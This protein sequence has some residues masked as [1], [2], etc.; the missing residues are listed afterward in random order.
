MAF[1]VA[2]IYKPRSVKTLVVLRLFEDTFVVKIFDRNFIFYLLHQDWQCGFVFLHNITHNLVLLARTL[3]KSFCLRSPI[4]S[5][6]TVEEIP[7]QVGDDELF[8]W[9]KIGIWFVR[10]EDLVA[11][12]DCDEIF[13]I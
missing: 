6:M 10:I 12:H 4:K 2:S 13:S 1:M 9:F 7:D 3:F 8:Y 11:V 5:G